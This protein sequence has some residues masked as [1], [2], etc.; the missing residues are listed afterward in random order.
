[1]NLSE[2]KKLIR[3]FENS[4]VAEIEVEQDGLR[5]Q[6]KKGIAP[7]RQIVHIQPE[8]HID[9]VAGIAP[10]APITAAPPAAPSPVSEPS[11]EV[12]G[13]GHMITAPMVG[14]FFRS[15]SPTSPPFVEEGDIV[16][17]GQS[18]CVI[19]AMKLMNEIESDL[20]GRVVSILGENGKPVEF[21][22]PLF[23]IEPR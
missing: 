3:I 19:E 23:E 12:T 10:E 16:R 9:P 1:M 13:G 2:I 6:M 11:G 4:G 18:L 14:T 20:D 5:V 8:G 17:V 22:M 7:G 21:G 15:P